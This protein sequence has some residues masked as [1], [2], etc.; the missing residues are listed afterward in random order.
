MWPRA[1]GN[2]SMRTV[3]PRSR[4]QVFDSLGR[5][6]AY[7]GI[8]IIFLVLSLFILPAHATAPMNPEKFVY[9]LKW[10]GIK[11]GTASLQLKDEGNFLRILS[12]AQSA[13]WV[14]VFYTVDDRVESVV[15]KDAQHTSFLPARYRVKIR[16]GRHRRDKEVIFD[17]EAER[18]IYTDRLN[19][20]R[21]EIPISPPVFDPL[22][23]F[24]Y[25]RTLNLAVGVP[26]YITVFDS[27]KVWNVEVQVL[28]REKITTQSGT[29]DTVVV[30]PLMKSEGIFSS[31]GDVVIWLTDDE[32]R[33]PVKMQ[34][35]V[36][37]GSITAILVQGIT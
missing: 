16:E 34:T 19:N 1:E 30:K 28:R 6:G 31:K 22:S 8:F 35:K 21:K 36:A 33:I 9:D 37:I 15:A 3:P 25:L 7:K 2:A 11:A 20:E 12:T 10:T 14:S 32:R 26:I 18:A 17:F 27:K 23:G 4:C 5:S 29:F 13:P 24:F